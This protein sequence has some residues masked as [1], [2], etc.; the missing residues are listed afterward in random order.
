M[1][2]CP[3]IHPEE[4][5]VSMP[6]ETPSRPRPG[7]TRTPRT[8]SPTP[9]RRSPPWPCTTPLGLPVLPLVYDTK[10][11]WSLA[12]G[13]RRLLRRFKRVLVAQKIAS[14]A[15]AD[16]SVMAAPPGQQHRERLRYVR[17]WHLGGSG[18]TTTPS[19][20][21]Y[22][23][24]LARRSFAA[25]LPRDAADRGERER[26]R[27]RGRGAWGGPRRSRREDV[28]DAVH[29]GGAVRRA[30]A[31]AREHVRAV[32]GV[33]GHVEEDAVAR[34]RR[35]ASRSS[36]AA[37]ATA[38]RSSRRV[39]LTRGCVGMTSSGGWSWRNRRLGRPGSADRRR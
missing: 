21:S 25:Q 39:T 24:G 11:G 22:S 9:R 16:A 17:L 3:V 35:R 4:P 10:S 29:G 2:D 31:L 27:R 23:G 14:A 5:T 36:F 19:S 12:Q 34:R 33:R 30:E 6:P 32:G 15:P 18:K 13:T 7:R 8:S 1:Y 38:P 26:R 20:S 28:L 37:A